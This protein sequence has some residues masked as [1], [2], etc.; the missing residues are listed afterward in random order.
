MAIT[1]KRFPAHFAADP[2]RIIARF[3]MIGGDE[4]VKTVI[5]NIL[6]LSDEQALSTLKQVL[7]DFSKR[8]RNISRIF[9]KSYNYVERFVTELGHDPSALST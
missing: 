6:A 2:K 5:K 9:E 7:R 8:H 1:V 4:E 3:Y